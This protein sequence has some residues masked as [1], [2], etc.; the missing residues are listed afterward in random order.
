MNTWGLAGGA[1]PLAVA[2]QLSLNRNT[3]VSVSEGNTRIP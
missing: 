2:S 3:L 1:K